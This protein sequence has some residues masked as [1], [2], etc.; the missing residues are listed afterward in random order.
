MKTFQEPEINLV[1]LTTEDIIT[2]SP[3]GGGTSSEGS[4]GGGNSGL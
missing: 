1:K 3:L 2:T 4:E